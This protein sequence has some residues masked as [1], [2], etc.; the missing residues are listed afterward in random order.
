M[1]DK[2]QQLRYSPVVSAT[3]YHLL[4][5]IVSEKCQVLAKNNHLDQPRSSL[6]QWRLHDSFGFFVVSC[7]TF[8]VT[9]NSSFPNYPHSDDHSRWTT[10]THGFKPFTLPTGE[11]FRASVAGAFY[12]MTVDFKL[13]WLLLLTAVKKLCWK[14]TFSFCNAFRISL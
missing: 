6:W 11:H 12:F 14:F 8:I 9:N 13:F 4:L 5:S 1:V 3:K 10:D 7:Y 2:A